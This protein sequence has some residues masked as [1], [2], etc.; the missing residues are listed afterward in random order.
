M[1]NINGMKA[2]MKFAASDTGGLK[3]IG[4]PRVEDGS[5]FVVAGE[6]IRQH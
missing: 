2:I 1:E 6:V 5:G 4:Y 3:V